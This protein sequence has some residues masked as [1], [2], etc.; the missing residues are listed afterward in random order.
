MAIRASVKKPDVVFTA[1][2][3]QYES[4]NELVISRNPETRYVCF[5][6]DSSLTSKTWEVIGVEA[7]TQGNPPRSSREIKMLGHKFFPEGTRSLY[8]DN[9]VRLKVDGSI[10]LEEWLKDSDIAFMRHYSRKTVRGEFFVCSAYGLDDQR[11]IW[12]QFKYYKRKYPAVLK[13]RPHWGGMIARVNSAETDRFMETWKQQ[14]DTFT[15]RDQLSINVSSIISGVK[16]G[17][18]DGENDS[19]KWH[20][21]PVHT[22]RKIQMRDKTSGR[23]FRKLR[24]ILNGLRYGY[25]FY[26]PI[27]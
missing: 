5:T 7:K 19:S 10:V 9:T 22:N 26:I 3:G 17:T 6:D 2:F 1:L 11:I 14:F 12:N 23:R 13:Q 27:G 8:V 24:I 15:K 4:L 25:R 20:E 18:I 21:W 16:V